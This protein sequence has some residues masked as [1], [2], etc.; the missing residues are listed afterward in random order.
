M[1]NKKKKSIPFDP[2][3]A[4]IREIKKA[5]T[6][7]EKIDK[8]YKRD[9]RWFERIS[10]KIANFGGSWSFIVLFIIVVVFWIILNSILL[11]EKPVDPYPY[12]LLNLMLSCLA[13]IQAPIILMSQSRAAKRD[14]AKLEV[15][16]EKDL[17]DLN[18][19]KQT[20]HMLVKMQKDIELIKKKMKLKRR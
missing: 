9:M 16:L 17:R 1:A 13:A 5:E 6:S 15:D 4:F 7:L 10:D 14:Q 19:D 8:I 3:N 18:L 11:I 12:I 2:L 20:V